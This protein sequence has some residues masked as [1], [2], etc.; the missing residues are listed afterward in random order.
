M[1]MREKLYDPYFHQWLQDTQALLEKLPHGLEA[2]E[3]SLALSLTFERWLLLLKV[4]QPFA[5]HLTALLRVSSHSKCSSNG[6]SQRNIAFAPIK[7]SAVSR[8]CNG[9][10]YLVF[11][12][13]QSH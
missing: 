3:Q 6:G 2:P 1:Q 12:A 5:C 10:F 8:G 7:M 13:M 9:F 11:L 4:W